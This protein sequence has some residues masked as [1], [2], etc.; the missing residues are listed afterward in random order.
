MIYQV[1][2]TSR[3]HYEQPVSLSYH[4]LYLMPRPCDH[5]SARFSRL[6]V[7]PTPAHSVD[8]VDY[9]GNP[10]QTLT[11]QDQHDALSVSARS[12]VAVRP[13]PTPAPDT[14]EPW[15][16]VVAATRADLSADGLSRYEQ[17]FISPGTRADRAALA[18]LIDPVFVPGRPVLEAAMD[19]T[20]RINSGFA[21]DPAAT[22]ITT[23]VEEVIAL[24]RGVCQDFAHLQIACLRAVGL[25]TRYVSGYLLTHPP[26]G[27]PRLVGADASH[28]WISVWCGAAGWIDLDPTN[29]AVVG[30]E[31]ITVAWGRDYNDVSPVR[32]VVYGGGAHTVEVAVD[33]APIP[34]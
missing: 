34:A 9:F 3:Y 27:Q 2:H 7:T 15:D 12:R 1:S 28:A 33:V 31:H 22:T 25:P 19:L 4:L 32:G 21:Y 13:R 29:N 24:R 26:P 30:Q 23:R 5:Q 17:T 16:M 14:T 11:I 20:A 6:H 10:T 18:D 8:G